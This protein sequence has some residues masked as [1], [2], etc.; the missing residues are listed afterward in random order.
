MGQIVNIEDLLPIRKK[1]KEERKKVIFTNGCFDLLHRGHIEYLQ[2]A[3]GLG[4]ILI[5]G[6]NSDS[7][8]RALKGIERPLNPQ[9]DRAIILANICSV[10]Y[11]IV[12][13]ELT[14]A[15]LIDQIIPDILAKGGDYKIE[16]II[17]RQTVWKNGGEVIVIP[18][19]KGRASRNIIQI[20]IERYCKS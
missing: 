20:I 10:D 6:L 7:S 14:P 13:E 9:E 19:V 5:V 15:K 1:A 3:K 18:E 12:F 11:V 2:A 17:G 4:D 8:V 16:E